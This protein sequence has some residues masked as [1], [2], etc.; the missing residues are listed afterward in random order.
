MQIKLF[1]TNLDGS[2]WWQWYTNSCVRSYLSFV[3]D[4]VIKQLNFSIIF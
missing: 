1:D 3:F 4:I 2:L